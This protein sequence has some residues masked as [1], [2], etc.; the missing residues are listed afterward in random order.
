[1]VCRLIDS[2]DYYATSD[3]DRKWTTITGSV[4]LSTAVTRTGPN[5]LR[6]RNSG[7][8]SVAKTF[9]SQAS[10]IVGYAFQVSTLPTGIVTRLFEFIDSATV[11]CFLRLN[12]DGR[13]EVLRGAAIAVSGGVSTRAINMGIWYFLEMKVTIADSIGADSCKVRINGQDWI[14][15]DAGEDLKETANAT[16]DIIR[17]SNNSSGAGFLYIDNLYIFD[18]TDGGGTEPTNDDFAGDIKVGFHLPDGNGATNEF[19]GSDA[20]SVDNFLLVDEN[21]TDDDTTYVE[22]STIGHI[23]LYTVEDL[24]ETPLDFKAVQ[25]NSVIRKDDSGVKSVRMVIRPTSTNFFGGNI[26]PQDGVYTNEIEILNEDP[27][28]EAAWTESGFNATEF[29]LEITM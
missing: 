29:G 28:T 14:T 12:S 17:M 13:L 8:Q 4:I 19:T 15:V 9:D 5:V 18:G 1:M 22:S 3:L 2:F 20:D 27:E 23:D 21:P 11:Q 16:A 25:I 6:I 10:W 7:F 26:D 24:A